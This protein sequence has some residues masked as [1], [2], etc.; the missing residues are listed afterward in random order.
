[1]SRNTPIV[2]KVSAVACALVLVEL[3][4]A[5]AAP[6]PGLPR[7]YGV[8]RVDSPIP[9]PGGRIGAGLINMGDANGDGEDD[10]VTLQV[11]GTPGTN[12]AV[13]IIS[14]ETG[15]LIRQAN[16]PDAGNTVMGSLDAGAIVDP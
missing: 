2:A 15:Q 9:T 5:T 7:T 11:Q 14:G 6:A 8:Q 3:L 12:G 13:Y 16:M 4:A 1:M 10:F